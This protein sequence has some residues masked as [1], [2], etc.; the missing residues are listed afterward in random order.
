MSKELSAIRRAMSDRMSSW[1]EIFL[2]QGRSAFHRTL[3]DAWRMGPIQE[4]T[5]AREVP[6]LDSHLKNPASA[7]VCLGPCF[8]DDTAALAG[9]GCSRRNQEAQYSERRASSTNQES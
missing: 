6:V 4:R 3:D 7:L 9:G 5:P 2:R 8:T 1:G